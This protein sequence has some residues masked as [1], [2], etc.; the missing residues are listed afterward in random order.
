MFWFILNLFGYKVIYFCEWGV[1]PHRYDS[2][3][4][5]SMRPI[6]ENM[7]VAPPWA[8]MKIVKKDYII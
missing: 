3:D 1:Y 2:I 6:H 8:E 4:N 7:S 5:Q